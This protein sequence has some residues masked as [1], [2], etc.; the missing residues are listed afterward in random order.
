MAPR[1]KTVWWWVKRVWIT[2]GI[3][4]TV[5]FVAWSLIAFRASPAARRAALGDARVQVTHADEAWTFTPAAGRGA[6]SAGLL[7]FPG[8]LVD[9]IAYAPLARAAAAAGFPA[10]IVE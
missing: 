6:G 8:A 10:F 9:P 7:F 4:A 2:L 3:S 5:V 1:L